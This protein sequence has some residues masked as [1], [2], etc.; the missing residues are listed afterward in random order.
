MNH[1]VVSL[2]VAENLLAGHSC[3]LNDLRNEY[4]HPESF[5]SMNSIIEEGDTLSCDQK[6]FD[7]YIYECLREIDDVCFYCVCLAMLGIK[8]E[9]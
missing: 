7:S 1:R 6:S 5:G 3:Y 9:V 2:E 4:Q 8:P